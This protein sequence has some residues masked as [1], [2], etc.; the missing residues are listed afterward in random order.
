MYTHTSFE[1][2]VALFQFE[3]VIDGISRSQVQITLS[4]GWWVKVDVCV[5]GASVSC[6]AR[7]LPLWE[8]F[9]YIH[10]LT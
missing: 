4:I 3:L 8:G 1:H 10:L 2:A 5:S 9:L 7:M 6:T